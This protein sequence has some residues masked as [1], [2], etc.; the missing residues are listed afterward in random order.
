MTGLPNIGHYEVTEEEG[1]QKNTWKGLG[2]RYVDNRLFHTLS[3]GQWKP[4]HRTELDEEKWP[5][6]KFQ[7][8]RQ[9]I[10]QASQKISTTCCVDMKC[11]GCCQYYSHYIHYIH[12]NIIHSFSLLAKLLLVFTLFCF[13]FCF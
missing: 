7:Q 10:G 13:R 1:D 11:Q 5:A 4:Q 6:A 8:E 2:E 12:N 9:G 3:G